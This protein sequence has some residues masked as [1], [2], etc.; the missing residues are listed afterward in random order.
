VD[1]KAEIGKASAFALLQRDQPVRD[2]ATADRESRNR[3]DGGSLGIVTTLCVSASLREKESASVGPNSGI[4][5]VSR[6]VARAQRG[7]PQ[8]KN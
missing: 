1:A 7:K 4:G 6:K 8:P 3:A 2:A 5:L